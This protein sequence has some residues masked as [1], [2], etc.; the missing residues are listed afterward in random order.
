MTSTLKLHELPTK[1]IKPRS[2]R[3]P[4]FQ[5]HI[6][7]QQRTSHWSIQ[8]ITRN[9]AETTRNINQQLAE[10]K[11]RSAAP[12]PILNK[13][14]CKQTELYCLDLRLSPNKCE[15][16]AWKNKHYRSPNS[17]ND[18]YTTHWVDKCDNNRSPSQNSNTNCSYLFHV[19]S[20]SNK[21]GTKTRT[22]FRDRNEKAQSP[23]PMDISGFPFE[24]FWEFAK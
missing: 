11:D 20:I 15:P 21:I 14:D 18:S 7:T 1:C 8:Q 16:A 22:F 3:F 23:I 17:W 9:P 13:K 24:F 2:K 5:K 19:N 12:T 10:N 4:T 6:N